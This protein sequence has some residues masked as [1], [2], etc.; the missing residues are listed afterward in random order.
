[1][2]DSDPIRAYLDDLARRLRARSFRSRRVLEEIETHLRDS[3]DALM[4]QGFDPGTAAEQAIERFGSPTQVLRQFEFEAPFESEVDIMIGKLLMPV[5]ALSVLFGSVFLVASQFDD[6]PR[7]MYLVKLIVSAFVIGSSA[8]LFHQA[9][10]TKPLAA[11][12][13]GLELASALLSI[14]IGSAGASFTIHLG[15]VT[16]DWEMYGFVGAG[17]LL[18][19][20]VLATVGLLN[21]APPKLTA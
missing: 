9:W 18:L 17:L 6:A 10:T 13:R 12:H 15:L 5:A 2:I 16:H 3:A 19:Q 11:W 8:I 14:A 7:A 4:R 21:A 1:M 20:G